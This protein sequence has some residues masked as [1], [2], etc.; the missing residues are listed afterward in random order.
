MKNAASCEIW[1][2]L[3]DTLSTDTL[4]AHC[5]L[6]FCPGPRLSEGRIRLAQ[7]A[8]C[9]QLAVPRVSCPR[10]LK[11][12]E[13]ILLLVER[14]VAARAMVRRPEK[15]SIFSA[16]DGPGGQ[17]TRGTTWLGTFPPSKEG[18]KKLFYVDL[19]SDEMTR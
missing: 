13:R 14:S 12:S 15:T 2:E 4:N 10:R 7:E 11:V 18:G 1:C 8:S 6:G 9:F 3:Q 17:M 5:G 16:G 19:R